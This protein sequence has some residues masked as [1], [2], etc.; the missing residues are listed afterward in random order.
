MAPKTKERDHFVPFNIRYLEMAN[1]SSMPD[2]L[3]SG[4]L[5]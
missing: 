2:G 4:H 1:P 3:T 5:L